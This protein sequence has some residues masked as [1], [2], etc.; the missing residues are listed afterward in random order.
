MLHH[1]TLEVAPDDIER[2]LQLWAL[3]GFEPVEPPPALAETFVWVERDGTQI[4]LERNQ[5]PTVPPHGHAAVVVADFDRAVDQLRGAGFEVKPGRE[6]WG[7][8]RAKAIAPGG[9]RVEFMAKPPGGPAETANKD[10]G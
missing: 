10:I 8:K 1:V 7:A 4:H 9:H 6:H 3:L 5:S 2:S